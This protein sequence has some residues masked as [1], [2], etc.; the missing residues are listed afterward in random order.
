MAHMFCIGHSQRQLYDILKEES[1]IKHISGFLFPLAPGH[2]P[3][4]VDGRTSKMKLK[5]YLRIGSHL[6][7]V[8]M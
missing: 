5:Q 8:H 7:A 3:L 4:N 6:K 2:C 1:K